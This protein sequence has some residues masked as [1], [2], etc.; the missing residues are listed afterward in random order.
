VDNKSEEYYMAMALEEARKGA[1]ATHPNPMVGAVIVE[2]GVVVARGYH[3][4]C[5]GPHAEKAALARLGRL[6]G[7]G[8]KMYVTL[9]PCSTPG[10]T[11]ACTDLIL[12][13]GIREIRVGAIDPNPSHRGRGIDILRKAGIKVQT[14]VLAEECEALNYEFNQRMNSGA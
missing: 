3:A 14:G 5:G 8:A 13:S 10:R 4:R 6:P 12:A 9:E 7:P 2:R 1:G 11:G